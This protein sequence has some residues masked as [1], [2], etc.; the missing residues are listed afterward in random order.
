VPAPRPALPPSRTTT[1]P[2]K[3]AKYRGRRR[4]GA[5]LWHRTSTAEDAKTHP[6]DYLLYGPAFDSDG[7]WDAALH[8][9]KATREDVH[10]DKRAAHARIV[11]VKHDP[12]DASTTGEQPIPHQ[13]AAVGPRLRAPRQ[14]QGETLTA[15]SARTGISVSILSR[16]ESGRR[17]P[18][19]E[20]LVPLARAYQVAI[21]DLI[22]LPETAD[23]RV[24]QRRVVRSGM[25]YIPLTLRPGDPRADKIVIP[26]G[27]PDEPPR[28]QVH[29]GSHWCDILSGRLGLGRG[30]RDLTLTAGA[31]AVFDT[32]TP[33]WPENPDPGPTEILVL[34]QNRVRASI[35][36]SDVPLEV[37]L[38]EAL[39]GAGYRV[40]RLT[41]STHQRHIGCPFC[42]CQRGQW[43]CPLES[44]V[45]L[46]ASDGNVV[47]QTSKT[48]SG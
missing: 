29:E 44:I 16:L 46:T 42:L 47:C 14:H 9:A 11:A 10:L 26:P 34:D 20:L 37:T 35:P 28:Q 19:L 32:R 13:L 31:V 4:A 8:T 15:M 23:P 3:P 27:W 40:G 22:D 39:R 33:H 43:P 6:A 41:A 25:T 45:G 2:G 7:L 18:T 1:G 38:P 48:R 21:G 24:Q 36:R 30:E 5:N 12:R 17:R